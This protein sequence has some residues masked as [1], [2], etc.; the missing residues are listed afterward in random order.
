MNAPIIHR[1]IGI[2]QDRFI[3]KGDNNSW[4]DE[5]QPTRA[6]I[7]GKLWI[8]LPKFGKAV[9]WVR[10]P[11]NMALSVGL[12]GGLFMTNMIV[13]KPNQKSKRKK[14]AAGS[15]FGMIE[16]ALY[17][18]GIL[19]LIALALSIFA[20]SRPVLRTADSI[21][22][23]QTGGFLYSAGGASGVYDTG[24]AHSGDPVFTKLACT[25]NLGFIY[26]LTGDQLENIS[27]SQHFDATLID[28]QSGWRRTIP[29]TSDTK[30]TG[31]SYVGKTTLDLCQVEALV[32][33]VEQKTGFHL[34]N[35][36]LVLASHVSVGGKISGQ[37]FA[38]TFEPGLTFRFD[39]LHFYIAADSSNA[40]P[41]KTVQAGFINNPAMVN[42]TFKL[43]GV[44]F[45]I[46]G[47]RIISIIGLFI[48]LVGL[49]GVGFYFFTTTKRNPE[50]IIGM[51]YG[52]ILL[53]IHDQGLAAL[54]PAIDVTT[55]EDLAKMAE[56]QN[57]MILH[58]VR[59]SEH[60]SV[61]YYFLQIE[62]ITYRYVSNKD[63]RVEPG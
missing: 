40:N 61:D 33:S 15:P 25:L 62:G 23:E 9:L 43:A 4:I 37:Q 47:V 11:I 28:E 60:Y 49:L 42:N 21:Q 58:L 38:S 7:A 29:L 26:S 18:F 53:D 6:E 34:I 63:P 54:S 31:N 35:Y 50:A 55:I 17:T 1:I 32:A 51:K 27:G 45:T 5:Y 39:S 8:Y 12:L 20:F 57:A 3:M 30:F 59:D 22:Y 41:M 24:S 2:Q 19:A 14:K 48:S 36:T 10:S 16:M 56:R 52:S 46:L 44:D 13:Q